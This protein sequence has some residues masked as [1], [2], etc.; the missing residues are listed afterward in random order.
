MDCFVC[1]IP[2]TASI[3]PTRPVTTFVCPECGLHYQDEGLRDQAEQARYEL[4]N[5]TPTQAYVTMFERILEIIEPFIQGSVLDYGSGQY[6]VLEQLLSKRYSVTSYDLFFHPVPL[7]TYETVIAIEVV[8]HFIDPG[9]EW[10]TLLSLVQ[11]GGHLIVQTRLI[12]LPFADWWYQRD[13]THRTYYTLASLT[14]LAD[15]AG[16]TVTFSNNH[17]IMVMKRGG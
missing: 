5:N 1:D 11:P 12:E 7:A 6:K 13:P 15:Q 2:M 9:Q 4:H 3:N 17:S 16:F 8:E 10:A 14:K